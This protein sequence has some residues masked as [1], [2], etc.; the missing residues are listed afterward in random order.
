MS[1]LRQLRHFIALID[2]GHFARAAEALHLSQPALTR[3][4]QALEA[5]LGCTLVNRHSR[6]ITLTEPGR[7]VE[8]HARRLLAGSRAMIEAVQQYD[9]LE[10]GQLRL[11]AGPFPAARLVPDALA[12]LLTAHPRLAVAVTVG[13]WW[14]LR[15]ALLDERIEMFVADVRELQSDSLLDIIELPVYPGV[16][17][18][19]PGH[20]LLA[21]ARIGFSDLARFP[22][23]GTQLPAP[24]ARAVLKD[25][26]R[27]MLS[28]QCENFLLLMRL[29]EQGD[30]V[31]MAPR[32]VVQEALDDGSVVELGP[33]TDRLV[34]HSA[35]G[36]VSRRGHCLS[37]AG[38]AFKARLTRAQRPIV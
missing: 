3:S 20:P 24:V 38:E 23:A 15:E 30:A 31:C 32:D 11:G 34:H 26:G 5:S 8:S 17:F 16:L 4:L 19:R 29:T 9:N 28:V 25:T 2:H 35:Y 27:E 6:G 7:L 12:D 37:P 13:D 10:A 33:L 14:G 22:L 36:L 1:D 18:C 21:Q